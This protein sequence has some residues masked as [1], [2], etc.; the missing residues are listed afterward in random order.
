M[1]KSILTIF[2]ALFLA[3]SSVNAASY[4]ATAEAAVAYA[5]QTAKTFKIVYKLN[6]G[7]NNR[8]N[9][10]TYKKTS[11]TITLNNPTRTGYTFGGWFKD[12]RF[13]TRVTKIKKGSTGKITLYAKWTANRYNIRF[14]ANRAQ[15]TMTDKTNLRYD[16]EYRL[17]ANV[18]KREGYTFTGWNTKPDGSGISYSDRETVKNLSAKNGKTVTLYAQWEYILSTDDYGMLPGDDNGA[19]TTLDIEEYKI[20]PNDGLDDTDA[21]NEALYVAGNAATEGGI[22]TVTLGKGVYDVEIEERTCAIKMRSNVHLPL[23]KGAVI[24]ARK[25]GATTCAGVIGFFNCH[26]STLSGGKI[27]GPGMVE[28]EDIYGIWVKSSK[29]IKI[30]GTEVRDSQCDGVYLSP[31]QGLGG[32]STG[33]YGISIIGCNIHD[34]M[35]NNIS[36]VDADSVTIKY[37]SI[38]NSGP[39]Q[40]SCGICI[41]PN[42]LDSSGDKICK[43]ILI[44][45]TTINTGHS[46]NDWQYR[47]FY[48]Y[49]NTDSGYDVAENVKI[50][51]CTLIGYYGNYNGKNVIVSKD[52]KIVGSADGLVRGN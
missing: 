35:R 32:V 40:P 28:G 37:C 16:K 33:N 39:R 12:K 45:D 27:I 49:D 7:K 43:D 51:H 52:T 5:K 1:K 25:S 14:R 38:S 15:G 8:K 36:I 44:Q 11:K 30:S 41:E 21:I 24:R 23:A 20:I 4:A 17:P 18:F 9:P 29:N 3:F 31:Q 26:N 2:L 6:G 42:R 10:A 47:T 48:S 22:V 50:D 19:S 34:N 46:V 13:K